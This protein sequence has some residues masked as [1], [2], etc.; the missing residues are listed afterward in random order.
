M[1]EQL[2]DWTSPVEMEG[3]VPPR[4][5][6]PPARTSW[7]AIMRTASEP[8]KRSE[9]PNRSRSSTHSGVYRSKYFSTHPARNTQNSNKI[10][11]FYCPE[12]ESVAKEMA[13]LCNGEIV[14]GKCHFNSFA[15]GWPNLFLDDNNMISR[16]PA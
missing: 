12:M 3:T 9:S 11:L 7:G 1:A 5:A 4:S 10:L 6:T 2:T 13:L 8:L 16:L 14:L 15:D